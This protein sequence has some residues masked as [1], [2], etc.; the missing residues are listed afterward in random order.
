MVHVCSIYAYLLVD[1]GATVY[2]L[3]PLVAIKFYISPDIFNEP[4]MVFTP[5]GE[6]VV[7]KR[8][9]RDCLIMFINRVIHVE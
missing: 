2:F 3:T 4:F 9:Y 1:K 6:S 7:E 5:M 8:A